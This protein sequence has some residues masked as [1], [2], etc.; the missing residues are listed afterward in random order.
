MLFSQDEQEVSDVLSVCVLHFL[1]V[2]TL[3]NLA[4]ISFVKAKIQIFQIFT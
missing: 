3:P 1:K 2:S 4:S